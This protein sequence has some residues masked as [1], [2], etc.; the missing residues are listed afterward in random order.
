M[1]APLYHGGLPGLKP[2]DLLKP[3]PPRV[4]DG[5]PCCVARAEGRVFTVR[6]ARA[7]ALEFPPAKR[8]QMLR[9]LEGVDPDAP[10]DPPTGDQAV[11]VTTDVGYA[12]W[13]AARSRGDLY[14]VEPVG[15][16]VRSTEDHFPTW[17]CSGA[18]VVAV[19]RRGVTLTRRDRRE[20]ER[21]WKKADLQAARA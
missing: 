16:A 20:L 3:A 6:E 4:E 8:D 18:R 5:C 2:G 11:Y 9:A 10:F 1:S 12:T 7:W 19:V 21:R 17:K 14:R 15:E 13:Y